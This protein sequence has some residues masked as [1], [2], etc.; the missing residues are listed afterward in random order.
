[1]SKR[2]WFECVGGEDDG[3]LI[4][5]LRTET[6]RGV[7]TAIVNYKT[8]DRRFTTR[9]RRLPLAELESARFRELQS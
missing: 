7:E 9:F 8:R 4:V 6:R 5:L 1:M 3:Q 2:R